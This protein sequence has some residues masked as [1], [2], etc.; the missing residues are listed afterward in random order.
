MFQYVCPSVSARHHVYMN[1]KS[2]YRDVQIKTLQNYNKIQLKHSELESC[3]G[4]V[5]MWL[6]NINF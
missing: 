2:K 1:M 3:T 6:A 4:S 5:N